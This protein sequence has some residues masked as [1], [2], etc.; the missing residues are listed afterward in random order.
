M[1]VLICWKT[2]LLDVCASIEQPEHTIEITTGMR[3]KLRSE[4]ISTARHDKTDNTWYVPGVQ[5]LP[6]DD[7]DGK[8]ALVQEYAKKLSI[9]NLKRKGR[10]KWASTQKESA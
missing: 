4:M 8:F 1:A 5:E 2:G 3:G 6:E 9:R 7:E 10:G